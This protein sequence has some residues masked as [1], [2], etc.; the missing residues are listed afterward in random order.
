MHKRPLISPSL[1]IFHTSVPFNLNIAEKIS[2]KSNKTSF[3][4]FQSSQ[5]NAQRRTKGGGEHW[6]KRSPP[7]HEHLS[8]VN[9]NFF[10]KM[11]F[12]WCSTRDH[13]RGKAKN[14]CLNFLLI[15]LVH[16]DNL[17]RKFMLENVPNRGVAA[18]RSHSSFS[19][20][21]DI[22]SNNKLILGGK[23]CF[24]SL[25]TFLLYTLR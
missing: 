14:R 9:L 24:I 12:K 1:V 3:T 19:A 4:T 20:F 5:D 6:G 18:P 22:A 16:F 23:N 13:A 15:Y 25:F 11:L 8:Y 21:S 17:N 2:P 10:T 7:P